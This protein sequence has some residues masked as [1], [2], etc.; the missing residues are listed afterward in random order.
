MLVP[1]G[2]VKLALITGIT[3]GFVAGK[4]DL[5]EKIKDAMHR[6]NVRIGKLNARLLADELIERKA[7]AASEN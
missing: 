3:V 5:D 1:D 6:Q 7:L 2:L 4:V